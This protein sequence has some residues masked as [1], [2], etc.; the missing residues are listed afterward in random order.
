MATTTAP[1]AK[2]SAAKSNNDKTDDDL[3]KNDD[4]MPEKITAP[5]VE[6]NEGDEISDEPTGNNDDNEED[7]LE[8]LAPQAEPRRWLIGKTPE[9]GGN[10]NQYS[11]YIQ[12]PLSY[13]NR[14]KFFAL[15]SK[16]VA[17]AL[18][19]S[20]K[21]EFGDGASIDVD[22]DMT[23]RERMDR[24][25]QTDFANA[26]SFMTLAFQLMSVSDTFLVDCYMLWLDVPAAERS[27]AKRI[28][29]QRWDP[30]NNKW[31]LKP[32]EGEEIVAVFIDQNYED[33]HDFFA[34]DVPQLWKRVQAR[35]KDRQD[36]KSESGL[37]KQ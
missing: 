10:E 30:D 32:G 7:P 34:E 25:R 6:G 20:G 37:S 13:I 26:G 8:I 15:V 2:K 22:E 27:W 33:I 36:R 28:M 14:M 29:S 4:G 35:Q 11:V 18:K 16:N 21:L 5:S 31:G 3:V 17:A 9:Y 24:L 19:Q 12:E 1:K 23:V